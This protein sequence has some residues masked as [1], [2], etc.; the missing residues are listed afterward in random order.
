MLNY[1]LKK[2]DHIQMMLLIKTKYKNSK[3]FEIFIYKFFNYL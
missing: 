1:N 2:L 3:K